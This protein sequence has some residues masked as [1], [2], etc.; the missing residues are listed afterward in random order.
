MIIAKDGDTIVIDFEADVGAAIDPPPIPASLFDQSERFVLRQDHSQ[1]RY[2]APPIQNPMAPGSGVVSEFS[3]DI[4]SDAEMS[5]PS[6]EG[7][8]VFDPGDMYPWFGPKLPPGG[9]DGVRDDVLAFQT[10][11]WPLAPDGP[12]PYRRRR[13]A[14]PRSA[15][16]ASAQP[17]IRS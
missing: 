12:P 6:I 9:N 3:V 2:A 10:D 1:H 4:G 5:D 7:N 13:P 15:T 17:A 14:Q 16:A 11:Y 8:E